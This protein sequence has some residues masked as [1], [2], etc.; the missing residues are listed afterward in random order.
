MTP[1]ALQRM[2]NQFLAASH[3]G[4]LGELVCALGAVQGQDHQGT[5]WSLGLRMGGGLDQAQV[6]AGYA[7]PAGKATIVRSWVLRGTLHFVASGD[8]GWM[9]ALL[10]PRLLNGEARR[11]RELELDEA[12]RRCSDKLLVK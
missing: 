2:H 6:E 5:L 7:Q 9:V 12:T 4:S 10:A 1:L 11:Y 8:L 3:P